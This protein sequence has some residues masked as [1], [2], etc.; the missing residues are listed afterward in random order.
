MVDAIKRAG[1]ENVT[2]IGCFDDNASGWLAMRNH[3]EKLK[4][5]TP[6]DFKDPGAW[7]A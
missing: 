5:G 2:K 6:F 1:Q 3:N 7:K 4:D